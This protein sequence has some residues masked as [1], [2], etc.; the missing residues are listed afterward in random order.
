LAKKV[1]QDQKRLIELLR[2]RAHNPGHQFRGECVHLALILY[3]RQTRSGPEPDDAEGTDLV[4]VQSPKGLSI[5]VRE[6]ASVGEDFLLSMTQEQR[7]DLAVTR[8]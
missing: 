4:L 1:T 5:T 8:A 6:G 3:Q 2:M 7:A